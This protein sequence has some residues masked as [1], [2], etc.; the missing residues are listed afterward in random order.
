MPEILPSILSADFAH[1]GRDCAM[2]LDA[3]APCL[4]VDVMDGHFVPNITIGL[5]VVQALKKATG[6]ELDVH[7][8]IER[9][10][11][12]IP[13][14]IKNGADRISFHQEACVH[15]DRTIHLAQEHGAKAGV[16]INPSTPVAMLTDVL[17]ILDYVLVM[18]VNPGFGG[19]KFIPNAIKKVQQLVAL[20]KERGLQFHIELDGGVSPENV[21]TLAGMGVD[22]F[23]AGSAIFHSVN[24]ADTFREMTRLA[25]E[26]VAVR[27]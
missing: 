18:S 13:G 27:V 22:W 25:N 8:M 11:D 9:P 12:Y 1:L 4:H 16:A 21:A 26:A 14:F 10:Q 23:V 6:A 3:G 20:R 19:Q 7:L 5:P 17:E 2:I 15:L 24:P